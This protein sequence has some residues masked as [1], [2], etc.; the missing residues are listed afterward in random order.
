HSAESNQW[1]KNRGKHDLFFFVQP[2]RNRPKKK[3]QRGT[4]FK[5]RQR[6]I[7]HAA[8]RKN[9]KNQQRANGNPQRPHF[10]LLS[11]VV[12][13]VTVGGAAIGVNERSS[14]HAVP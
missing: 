6:P 11:R 14:I 8:V 10:R 12:G 1:R 7:L 3:E 13:I 9:S 2:K 4:G 5:Y